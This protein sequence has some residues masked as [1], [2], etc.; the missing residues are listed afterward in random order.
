MMTRLALALMCLATTAIADGQPQCG[1]RAN[2][3][4]VL[5]DKYGETRRSVG[6]AADNL[7]MEVFA[8]DATGTWTITVTTP[9]GATCFVATGQGFEAVDEVLPPK[10]ERG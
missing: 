7:V 9:Q 2:V 4:G 1:P 10:G 6:L 8:S 5:A 3:L